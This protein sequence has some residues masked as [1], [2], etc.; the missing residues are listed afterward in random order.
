MRVITIQSQPSRIFTQ[1]RGCEPP[2]GVG[3]VG[4][5]GGG[6]VGE[7]KR[8]EWVDVPFTP[9]P[10]GLPEGMNSVVAPVLEELMD[11]R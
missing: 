5:F 1:G 6:G 11:C 8:E 4:F 3:R 10:A 9:R 7:R 2:Q